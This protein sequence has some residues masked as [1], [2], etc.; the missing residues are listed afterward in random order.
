MTDGLKTGQ[1]SRQAHQILAVGVFDNED[2][3]A[4]VIKKLVEEDFPADQLSLLH[5]TGGLGDDMLGLAYTD[6][7]KQ[8]KAWGEHGAIWGALGGLLAGATGLFVL[9]GIGPLLAAG[10]VVEALGGAI[11]GATMVGGGMA[12]AALLSE[13][14][15]ALHRI[16]V[17]EADIEIIYSAIEAGHYVVILHCDPGQAD[18]CAMRLGWAG[19]DPVTVMSVAH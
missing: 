4:R 16:G 13:L 8:V 12:G 7:A 11:A 5:K 15:S 2:K 6:T 17:P 3:V 9:P 10:P 18:H 19:A 1:P 14:A